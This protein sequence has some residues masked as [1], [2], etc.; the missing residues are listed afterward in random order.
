MEDGSLLKSLHCYQ[1]E[2]QL[3]AGIRYYK[4]ILDGWHRSIFLTGLPFSYYPY[5][6]KSNYKAAKSP[7]KFSKWMSCLSS[8]I[9]T[10]RVLF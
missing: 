2:T 5:Y 6:S 9:L 10:S 8:P 4:P 3:N 7:R 1:S